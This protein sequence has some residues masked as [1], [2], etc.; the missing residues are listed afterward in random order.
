MC[1]YRCMYERAEQLPSGPAP[2]TV[3]SS[4]FRNPDFRVESVI[5]LWPAITTPSHQPYFQVEALSAEKCFLVRMKKIATL[6]G[7]VTDFRNGRQ[8]YAPCL[9]LSC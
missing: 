7:A 9:Q 2:P 6:I 5:L 3:R 4:R 8:L 1:V